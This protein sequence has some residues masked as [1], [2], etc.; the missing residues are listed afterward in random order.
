[1]PSEGDYPS[2]HCTVRME[3][4]NQ[5]LVL[6]PFAGVTLRPQ[7]YFPDCPFPSGISQEFCKIPWRSSRHSIPSTQANT[8]F[9]YRYDS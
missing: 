3:R 4:A 7:R 1:M 5:F 6:A 8:K 9:S 2:R